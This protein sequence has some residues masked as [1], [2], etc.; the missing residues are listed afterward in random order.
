MLS[1]FHR[2][3]QL[4]RPSEQQSAC[5]DDNTPQAYDQHLSLLPVNALIAL[6]LTTNL[7][8]LLQIVAQDNSLGVDLAK[9][10]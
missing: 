1:E 2:N 3:Q 5:N 7:L 9:Q 8:F 4:D 10:D 6:K